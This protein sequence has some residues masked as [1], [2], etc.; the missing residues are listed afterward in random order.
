MPPRVTRQTE[1][2]PRILPATV[3]GSGWGESWLKFLIY[4]LNR[5]G[6]TSLAC[7]FPKPLLHVGL[8]PNST[9]GARSV[10]RVAGVTFE[11]YDSS[12]GVIDLVGRL[13]RD[14][15]YKTVVL[16]TVTGYQD[17]IGKELKKLDK[18]PES[19]RWGEA[20]G[21]FY[22]ERSENT[23]KALRA[24]VDLPCDTVFV[25]KEI[26]HNPP[27]EE[28]YTKSGKLMPDMRPRFLR[29]M[30]LDSMIG[31]HVGGA[32]A[33]WLQDACD[34]VC[35]LYMDKEVV[36]QGHEVNGVTTYTHSET[37][38]FV[39]VLRTTFH[40]NFFAGV[41]S[42]CPENVPDAIVNPT[43]QKIAQLV[44]GERVTDGVYGENQ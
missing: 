6:K 4:G 35:R 8:E 34:F 2:G 18:V 43:W 13:S 36:S 30:Q 26:D 27:K 41:R 33:Q 14:N 37:G 21:D 31:P 3:T 15:P 5:T 22:R 11:R 38:R 39:R 17:I 32:T 12:N 7:Q 9:G 29:G 25:A 1:N 23:R 42:P 19:I 28:K 16:D 24:F 40:P 20:E 10:S 44:N